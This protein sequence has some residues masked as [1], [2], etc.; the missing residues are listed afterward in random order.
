MKLIGKLA[1]IVIVALLLGASAYIIFFTGGGT[2]NG[3]DNDHEQNEND[4]QAPTIMSVTG[5]VTVIAGQTVT[6]S[7]LFSDNVG[8]T[9]ATLCYKAANASTWNSVSI[10]TGSISLSIPSTEKENYLYYVTV[11]D[12]A[13]NGPVGDPSVDGS[14]YYIITVQPTGGD[15]GNETLT[16]Q[17][18]IEE[19]TSETCRYCPNVGAI[20]ENLQS[21]PSYQNL[22]YYVSMVIENDKA[23]DYLTTVYNRSGDPTVYVDGGYK[24]ILGGLNPESNYTN[25]I[26][27]AKART[28]PQIRVTVTAEYKNTTNTILTNA[29][30]ENNESQT[31]SGM[32]RM[33][34]LEIIST[35]YNDYNGLKYRNA[36][37]DFIINEDINVAAKSNKTFSANWSAGNLD[38]ENLKVIAVV[39]NIT[40]HTAYSDPRTDENPFTAH[41]ADAVNATYVVKGERNLPP[42]VGILSP[43]KGKIYLRGN[44]ALPRLYKKTLLRSTWLI[45]RATISAYAK[46]DSGIAKVE[47]YLNNNLVAT[48]TNAPYNWTTPMK[49][50]KKPIIPHKYTIMVK[51]YDDTNKTASASIDVKAWWAF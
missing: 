7:A 26:L 49:L 50:L 41:Y 20:L 6:I 22:F 37:V 23:M 18:F 29:F 2:N 16:H 10:L 42:E 40:G 43:Q 24:V 51:A 25:A 39:F 35:K 11:N 17:V 9:Q 21:S 13:G 32:L 15:H 45:G 28:V 48:L 36:F 4:T 3:N 12:A 8:V 38:F 33:Y 44:L 5:N 1:V 34:L 30:V 19:S 31:Y 14:S 46:D 47:F 27:D